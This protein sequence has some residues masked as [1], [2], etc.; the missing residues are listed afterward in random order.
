MTQPSF[1]ELL[2]AASHEFLIVVDPVSLNIVATNPH[3]DKVLAR[4]NET[5]VGKTI[6]ELECGLQD[7]FYW[8]GVSLGQLD[9]LHNAEG[10]YALPDGDT[11]PVE[12]SIHAIRMDGKDWIL[13]QARDS[14]PDIEV[15]DRLEHATSLLRATLESTAEGILVTNL[16]GHIVNFNHRFAQ[17]WDIPQ[18]VLNR[19]RDWAVFRSTLGK[20][21]DSH[22][23][24]LRLRELV[25]SR[26]GETFDTFAL[27]DDRS[28]ECRSRPQLL[29]DQVLGRV[30]SFTDV[31]ERMRHERDLANARD[32]AQAASRAKTEFLSH[33]SH[34]LRTP[35]NA[36]IGFSQ[37][38]AEDVPASELE[39]VKAIEKAGGHLLSLINELLDMAKAEAGRLDVTMEIVEL[40][41]LCR[42]CVTMV[43]PLASRH[44]VQLSGLPTDDKVYVHA[45]PMRLKQM[46][47]NLLSNA[48]KYNNENGQASLELDMDKGRVRLVVVDTGIGI[49]EADQ[50]QLFQTFSRVGSKQ[51]KVEGTG[52]GLAFTRQ[53]AQLMDG[54]VGFSSTP[55]VGSRFWIDLQGA[56]TPDSVSAATANEQSNII[57]LCSASKRVLYIEDDTMSRALLQRILINHPEIEFAM[58]ESGAAGLTLAREMQPDLILCD[59]NLGDMSGY[60]ILCDLRDNPVTA[61]TPIFA[62]SGDAGPDDIA[63]ALGAGFSRY[64]VKPVQIPALLTAIKDILDE[65]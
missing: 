23:G 65:T 57:R 42:D 47:I 12:R 7:V 64:L 17:I 3:A 4:P 48:I 18:F 58:A 55:N 28:I 45:D 5:L 33:M 30:F 40:N 56:D 54:D 50:K 29:K 9:E 63:T 36:I 25:T 46:L 52:I 34:E 51:R 59:M 16:D 8:S 31:T 37:L 62:V 38:L 27:H 6:T 19:G 43:Q 13:I 24:R 61:N 53:L 35:L 20:L 14:R 2:L 10:L 1:A 39:S 60:E 32:A 44:H 15:T 22:A 11:L 49:S 41:S 21:A 26:D